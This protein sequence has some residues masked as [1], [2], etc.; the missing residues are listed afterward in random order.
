MRSR[1]ARNRKGFTLVES[2]I[3]VFILALISMA[4]ISSLIFNNR[5][6]RLNSNA[7]LAKNI[8]QGYFEQMNIDNFNNVVPYQDLGGGNSEGYADIAIN[9]A[10]PVWLDRALDIR[11]QV[12]FRFKGFGVASGGTAHSLTESGLTDANRYD[13]VQRPPWEV[14]EWVGKQLYLVDGPGQGQVRPITANTNNT[15]TLGG[16]ALNPQPGNGTKYMI[17]NGKT[18]EITTIWQYLGRNYSQ[19]MSSLI[20][21]YRRDPDL[22]F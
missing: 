6:T 17:G 13:Y 19:T 4:I 18:I 16:D 15:L 8:A 14:D 22:G 20:I 9:D 12:L 7:I 21:N 10:E 1:T 5:M 2:V 11:C 3:A